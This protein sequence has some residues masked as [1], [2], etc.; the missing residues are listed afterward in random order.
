MSLALQVKPEAQKQE[1]SALICSFTN[2]YATYR[3]E[4]MSFDTITRAYQANNRK[5][6]DKTEYLGE[7]AK[8]L[9]CPI[10]QKLLKGETVFLNNK[11]ISKVTG[12]K[13]RQNKNILNELSVSS[14]NHKKQF[15]Q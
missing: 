11:Y 2:P 6:T 12:C 10:I 9:L 15:Q 8:K 13:T 14:S 1:I 3:K 7:K 4:Y 5:I